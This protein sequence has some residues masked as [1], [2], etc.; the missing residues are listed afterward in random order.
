[1]DDVSVSTCVMIAEPH[2]DVMLPWPLFSKTV[3]K[4][5]LLGGSANNT[6]YPMTN[7]RWPMNGQNPNV[8]LPITCPQTLTPEHVISC[9]VSDAWEVMSRENGNALRY[10]GGHLGIMQQDCAAIEAYIVETGS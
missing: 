4:M 6:E 9:V 2:L 3:E 1:M 10:R 5:K 7:R 8:L